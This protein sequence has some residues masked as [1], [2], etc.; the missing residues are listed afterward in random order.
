MKKRITILS[1]KD[2]EEIKAVEKKYKNKRSPLRLEKLMIQ[3][4]VENNI[5][6]RV[7]EKILR[8]F[9]YYSFKDAKKYSHV[10]FYGFGTIREKRIKRKKVIHP[11]NKKE[12]W[13]NEKNYFVITTTFEI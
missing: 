6:K 3:I 12:V 5:S 4:A 8:D 7:V 9:F 13:T 11:K 10:S 1:L 2:L